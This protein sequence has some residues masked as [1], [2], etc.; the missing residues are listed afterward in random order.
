MKTIKT[1]NITHK[2]I[3]FSRFK[4]VWLTAV[5]C[6]GTDAQTD[7]HTSNEN[8]ISAIRFVLLAEIITIVFNGLKKNDRTKNN[9]KAQLSLT[10]PRDACEKFARLIYVRAVGL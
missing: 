3:S 10:N 8:S 9:K 4:L 2:H 5:R 7:R 6:M 1:E